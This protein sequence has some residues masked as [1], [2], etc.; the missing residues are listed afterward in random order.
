MPSSDGAGL[1]T[2]IPTLLSTWPCTMSYLSFCESDS[3]RRWLTGKLGSLEGTLTWDPLNPWPTDLVDLQHAVPNLCQCGQARRGGNSQL[4]GE[5]QP[6]PRASALMR[7][8]RC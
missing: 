8:P 4:G 5:V 2:F 6:V 7:L 3:G 1:A